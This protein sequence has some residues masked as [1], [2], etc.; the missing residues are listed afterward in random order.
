MRAPSAG[1]SVD[2]FHPPQTT[3]VRIVLATNVDLAR[4]VV[5]GRFREDLYY[6][7][8][9]VPIRIPPLRERQAD[10]LPL[11]NYLTR[12]LS[13]RL[14]KPVTGV[15]PAALE[16]LGLGLGS[17]PFVNGLLERG[18]ILAMDEQIEFRDLPPEILRHSAAAV[19]VPKNAAIVPLKQ[20]LAGPEREIIQRALDYADGNRNVAARLLGINRSTLFNKMRRLHLI[21]VEAG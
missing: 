18:I 8:N 6:R 12:V 19:S 3:D 21:G 20:A 1:V 11:V 10:L 15:A 13:A 17:R 14:Q 2:Q 4:E 5:E 9:V 16:A 7:I